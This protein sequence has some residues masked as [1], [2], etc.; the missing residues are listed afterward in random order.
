MKG[1]SFNPNLVDPRKRLSPT[2]EF[3]PTKTIFVSHKEK[4]AP[5]DIKKIME[6]AADDI[7]KARERIDNS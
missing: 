1:E 3:D 2:K 4:G 6:E 7:K 5:P